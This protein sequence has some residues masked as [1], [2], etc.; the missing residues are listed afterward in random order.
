MMVDPTS[1][2]TQ[3]GAAPNMLVAWT[4]LST[5]AAT[6]ARVPTADEASTMAELSMVATH[7][8]RPGFISGPGA[9]A[10]AGGAK[11]EHR[12]DTAHQEAALGGGQPGQRLAHHRNLPGQPV[13]VT[14]GDRDGIG[15][16][17]GVALH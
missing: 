8:R 10:P 4:A 1:G 12:A 2:A 5:N 11:H 17:V 16:L 9:G 6:A 7:L 15:V 3:S 13:G 14:H